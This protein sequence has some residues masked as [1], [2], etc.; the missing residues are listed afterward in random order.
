MSGPLDAFDLRVRLFLSRL[1]A[2]L[3]SR[4]RCFTSGAFVLEVPAASSRFQAFL[5]QLVAR[6]TRRPG[7]R[8][9][10]GFQRADKLRRHRVCGAACAADARS[11]RA[12]AQM[13]YA[14]RP[15]LS[16]LCGPADPATKGVLLFYSFQLGLKKYLYMKLES[17]GAMSLA[18]A[19]GAVERY[20]LK[21]KK[22]S[23]YAI[24]RE[25]AYKDA[26]GDVRARALAAAAANLVL[27]PSRAAAA[28]AYDTSLRTGLELFV[29]AAAVAALV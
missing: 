3:A 27:W 7:A 15:A 2:H 24:R 18:H 17:H 11:L 19:R 25:D 23:P 8:T 14:L 26:G 28:K 13:E 16:G 10:D 1:H 22:R 6:S 9:H 21:R 4:G 5:S 20:V 12:G 29:P